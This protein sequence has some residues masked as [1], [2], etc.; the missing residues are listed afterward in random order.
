M[1]SN[2][3]ISKPKRTKNILTNY[4]V[5]FFF[6]VFILQQNSNKTNVQQKRIGIE[7]KVEKAQ[8][9]HKQTVQLP[10]Q[11]EIETIE[12]EIVQNGIPNK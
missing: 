2:N 12:E 1:S 4:S 5:L 9:I 6:I 7:N 3:W 8:N 11:F 10:Y